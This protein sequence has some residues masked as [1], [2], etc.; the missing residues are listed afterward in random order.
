MEPARFA[1]V[2]GAVNERRAAGISVQ[3][4]ARYIFIC[5]RVSVMLKRHLTAAGKDQIKQDIIQALTAFTAGVGSGKPVSGGDPLASVTAL[6]D[7][8]ALL[9]RGFAVWQ[10]VI[11]EGTQSG[12]RKPARELIVGADG[13]H[14]SP[15]TTSRRAVFRSKIHS[16]WWPVLEIDP[17]DIQLTVP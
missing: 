15:M 3:F 1:N 7:A 4:I 8:Q 16:Q 2:T 11:E 10:T 13:R 5:P 6:G 9:H 14:P 12:Q 17:A